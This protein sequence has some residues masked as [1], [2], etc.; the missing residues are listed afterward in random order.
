MCRGDVKVI[1]FPLTESMCLTSATGRAKRLYHDSD[2]GNGSSTPA[3]GGLCCMY[4]TRSEAQIELAGVATP[5]MGFRNGRGS[6]DPA[7]YSSASRSTNW[8]AVKPLA[9]A[10]VTEY[11]P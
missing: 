4:T 8:P 6:Q 10:T 2:A 7:S 11:D 5:L 3:S 9:F 1:V